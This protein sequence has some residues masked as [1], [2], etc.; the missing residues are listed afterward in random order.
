MNRALLVAATAWLVAFAA[1]AAPAEPI[2]LTAGDGT[3]VFGQV[4]R[5]AGRKAPAIVAD[6]NGA[7]AEAHWRAVLE[8]LRRFTHR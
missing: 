7:G 5:G 1:A 8:F 4:W 3:R 6:S 2:M